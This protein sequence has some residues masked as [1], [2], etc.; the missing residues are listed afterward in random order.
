MHLKI[1]AKLS[2]AFC[3]S[4]LIAVCAGVVSNSWLSAHI[5]DRAVEER[6]DTVG[7]VFTAELRSEALRA[8]SMAE[9]L[10]LDTEVQ[11]LFAAR[12]R[13]GLERVLTPGYKVYAE[14]YAV[15]QMQFHTAPATSFL[16]LHNTKKFGDDL[17]GFRSTVVAVNQSR[18]PVYGLEYGVEG[19]GIRGVVPVFH[20][21][22]AVGSVEVGLS[23]GKPFFER[24]QEATGARTALYVP[25]DKA[26]D[27]AF[28]TFASTFEEEPSFDSA[29][30]A[31][32]L[33]G[34]SQPFSLTSGKRDL[35]VKLIPVQDYSGKPFGIVA[36]AIDP[37]ELH[38]I[39]GEAR[40]WSLAAG[41]LVLMAALGA[42]FLLSRTLCGPILALTQAMQA[43]ATGNTAVEIPATGRHDELGSMAA[44]V[45]VFR[46]G[47]QEVERLKGDQ[48]RL[49]R[50][51]EEERRAT[52]ARLASG[53]ETDV[54]DV[55]TTVSAATAAMEAQATALGDRAQESSRLA[56]SV[57]GASSSATGNVNAIAG[58][59]EELHASI[60]EIGRQ[61]Q[62]SVEI[63]RAAAADADR[64]DRIMRDLV[65]SAEQIG[66]VIGLINE[67]AAQ[68][69]L[70]AL[71]ATIEAARAGEA[72]KGFAVVAS[73]V[74]ALAGQTGRATE[75]IQT[76]VGDI[77]RSC[78]NAAQA[79]GTIGG[80]IGRLNEIAATV[81]AAVQQQ[82][83]ATRS[84]AGN[85]S[86]AATGTQEMA[87]NVAAVSQLSQE[88]ESA[89]SRLVGSVGSL[90]Q[91][92]E[93]LRGRIAGFLAQVKAA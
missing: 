60:G 65:V 2:L 71:N 86:G 6:L 73:E 8:V 41:A 29:A 40:N 91:D 23:F 76:K 90:A 82:D 10:V 87:A 27:K 68:T 84:I 25:G 59:V 32:A 42:A 89:A 67:I 61:I 37:A 34:A 77:R 14:R 33:R 70:L 13:E 31:G 92:T 5:I 26:G 50:Q 54:R 12:D 16:R 64:T 45:A 49:Q 18:T 43:L 38:G 4:V 39:L 52:L 56:M 22:A 7:K 83:S 30:M 44:A 81:A 11:R 79:I 20:Q 78:D 88:T 66:G 74:K 63:A 53:F 19:L 93:T 75:E 69:N 62:Q 9:T 57:E 48:E 24:F 58:A 72:G 47:L 46:S 17:S 85:V 36:L 51:A 28:T 21:G 3:G 1:G 15:R 80:T 55:M 35:T